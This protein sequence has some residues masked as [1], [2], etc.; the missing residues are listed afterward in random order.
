MPLAALQAQIEARYGLDSTAPVD[1]FVV[2]ERGFL[3]ALAADAA[4]VERHPRE[5]LLVSEADGT[6]DV[7]LFIDAGVLKRLADKDPFDALGDHNLD[8]FLVA[9]EGVSHFVYLAHNARFDK[10][11]TP[12]ELELQAEIDKF[13][14][15]LAL[16]AEQSGREPLASIHAVLF[17]AAR[18]GDWVAPEVRE[19]YEA[20]NFYAGKYCRQLIAAGIG[21]TT[22]EHLS[23]ELCRFY[24]LPRNAKVRHI[25]SRRT[26]RH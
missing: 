10:S 18:I 7:S 1:D 16:V 5:L 19:R 13:L 17:E 14:V 24:R 2:T 25:E 26:L 3:E 11:V 6:L 23:R 8:D 9:L 12:F 20:A 15:V 4:R 22:P 21:A